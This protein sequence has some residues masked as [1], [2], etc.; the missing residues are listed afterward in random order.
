MV[1]GTTFA[2][3]YSCNSAVLF[4]LPRFIIRLFIILLLFIMLILLL[5]WWTGNCL[6]VGI[7]G[8]WFWCS[9]GDGNIC[10]MSGVTV[11]DINLGMEL[12]VTGSGY[13]E[14]DGCFSSV[15]F[16]VA[17][18]DDGDCC[19]WCCCGDIPTQLWITLGRTSRST[20]VTSRPP[21]RKIS[22]LRF[23]KLGMI[24]LSR[25]VSF[26]FSRSITS[27]DLETGGIIVFSANFSPPNSGI[28]SLPCASKVVCLG[29][30]LISFISFSGGGVRVTTVDTFAATLVT[31]KPGGEHDG[32][33]C[34]DIKGLL[35][36][37]SKTLWLLLVP[38]VGVVEG[39]LLGVEIDVLEDGGGLGSWLAC[40]LEGVAL[41]AIIVFKDFR[42]SGFTR[43][44]RNEDVLPVSALGFSLKSKVCKRE[45]IWY[46]KIK[47]H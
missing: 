33:T 28:F 47:L 15:D 3:A 43:T 6:I 46:E 14:I 24:I 8:G 20:A 22:S 25:L 10:P 19:C 44:L 4:E 17:G 7:R 23:L 1:D 29:S 30:N 21:S 34:W 18:K 38:F 26:S 12:G 37:L 35:S 13:G 11:T 40:W 32:G 42:R 45:K 27:G 36:C 41:L 39:V 16:I 5:L 9:C 2:F 31:G